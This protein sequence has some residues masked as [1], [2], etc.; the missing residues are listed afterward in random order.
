MNLLSIAGS[1][2]SSGAGIQSDVKTFTGLGAY[3][4]TVITSITSQNTRKFGKIEPVSEKMIK[5][6]IDSIFSDFKVDAIKIGMVYNS[7]IIRTIHSKIS[8][9]NIPIILDPII[10]STTGGLLLKKDALR[11]YKKLLVPMSYVITPNVSEAITIAGGTI[12]NKDDLLTCALKIKNLGAKNVII[13]GIDFDKKIISDFV[14]EDSKFYTVSGRKIRLN[15]H[16]SGCN[17]S[18]ALALSIAKGKKLRDSVKYA[19][20]YTYNSIKNSK[21]I[22]KGIPITQYTKGMNNNQ[23]ILYESI[24]DFRNIKEIYSVIPEC[25]T[26][27]VFAKEKTKSIKDIL[28]VSGRIVKSGKDIVV[29]GTLAYGGSK[30]VGSALLE[31]RKKFP[32]L[33]A[34]VNIK[35]DPKMI[36]RSKKIGFHIVSYDR[37]K[38]PLKIKKKENSSIAWGI[39][40][41]IKNSKVMPDIIYHTGDFGKEPMIIVFGINPNKVVEKISKIL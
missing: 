34:A 8:K 3:A 40:Q 11:E 1:D 41:S 6:Q 31:I 2:P 39:K 20:K 30:H 27:F 32:I 22:G 33:R 36:S 26:N 23:R 4:L 14:L 17:F 19:K 12:K 18:A 16:G 15:N 35:Y 10:K 7:K 28:G 21:K 5:L 37:S 24:N 38:E 25:Q 9:L 29:A 13:T